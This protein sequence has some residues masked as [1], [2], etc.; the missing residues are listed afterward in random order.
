MNRIVIFVAAALGGSIFAYTAN[1]YA[2]ADRVAFALT[3]LLG[4]AFASGLVELFRHGGRIARLDEEL[5]EVVKKG[6]GALEASSPA[7]RE[8][9]RSRLEGV[10][11]PV[12]L[13]V[14]TPFLVGLLVMLGLLGTFLGLFETLRGAHAALAES[15]DVE[16]LRAGLSSPMRGLMRS[17]GT[18]A[19]GVSGSALLGLVAVFSRRR[20]AAFSAALADAVSGPLAGLS[21]SR[22]QLASMEALSAQG[23][24]LPEAAKALAE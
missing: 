18:S 23:H 5:T 8:L 22:R 7:L 15:Q 13:P 10:P 12:E 16:A 17:F 6:D 4:A 2:S 21:A 20:A 1:F 11:R 14:F 3:L 19:A 24:A 9:L